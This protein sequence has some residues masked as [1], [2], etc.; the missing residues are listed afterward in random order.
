MLCRY[1]PVTD[2]FMHE[3]RSD[4]T[5]D[6]TTD[7]TNDTTLVTANLSYPSD[8]LANELFHRPVCL[9]TADVEDKPADDLTSAGRVSDFGVELDTVEW[10]RVVGNSGE[11]CVGRV[12]DD[13]EVL[14]DCRE[15]V[16][17]R[18]P[19][20]HFLPKGVKQRV[21]RVI[22]VDRDLKLR[23]SVLAVVAFCD[24]ALHRPGHLLLGTVEKQVGQTGTQKTDL[25]TITYSKDWYT[26]LEDRWVN[27]RSILIVD[28][29]RGS[30]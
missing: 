13:M 20:L 3:L 21:N 14:G 29:I 22:S 5:V 7:C 18:H 15:L 19:Y 16:A 2:R 9:A 6:T 30:G 12:T 8:L 25:E 27:V 28:R 1:V 24:L 11:G 10:F 17:V 26:K 23:K 4:A